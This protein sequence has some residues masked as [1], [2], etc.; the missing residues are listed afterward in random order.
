MIS[1]FLIPLALGSS[2]GVAASNALHS[3][4]I[5]RIYFAGVTILAV[6]AIVTNITNL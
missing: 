2:A 5:Y 6:A 3:H 4:G 1:E